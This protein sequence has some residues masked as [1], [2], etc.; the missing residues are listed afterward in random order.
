M[1]TVEDPK[2]SKI[3]VACFILHNI[4]IEKSIPSA[5]EALLEVDDD[6]ENM[7]TCKIYKMRAQTHVHL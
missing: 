2:S 1:L 7:F 3:V 5:D 4:C 6:A